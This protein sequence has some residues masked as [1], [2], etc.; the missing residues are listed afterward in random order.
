VISWTS[1]QLNEWSVERVQ[2]FSWTSDRLKEFSDSVERVISWKSDQLNE[3]SVERVISWKSSVIQLN[4]WSVERVQWLSWTSDQLKEWSVE[5]VISWKSS[6][7]QLN[8][9]IQLKEWGSD[10]VE[11]V[12]QFD[13]AWNDTKAVMF[14][15]TRYDTK[16]V[17]FGVVDGWGQ[18]S[19]WG[20]CPTCRGLRWERVT[21]ALIEEMWSRVISLDM[22]PD[23]WCLM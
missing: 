14:G 18:G 1:D 4:E 13:N 16:S 5:R 6:V 15:V 9:V 23:Q 2:W 7:N 22:T 17:M 21:P 10:S 12:A 11:R 3:W 20:C 8:A 19:G